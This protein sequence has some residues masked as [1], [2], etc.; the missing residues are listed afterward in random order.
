MEEN[1]KFI[2]NIKWLSHAQRETHGFQ[3]TTLT[4]SHL[5]LKPWSY[6]PDSHSFYMSIKDFL[7]QTL[8]K[9]IC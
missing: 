9:R 8:C 7:G 1:D 4:I 2:I 6:A 3:S 5:D